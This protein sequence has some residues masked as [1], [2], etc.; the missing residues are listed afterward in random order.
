MNLVIAPLE[1]IA[2]EGL[3]GLLISAGAKGVPAAIVKRA[4]AIL[5]V[6]TSVTAI[7]SGNTVAGLSQLSTA[8]ATSD[9]DPGEALA[10]QGVV[11]QIATQASLLNN[12]LGST[13]LGTAGTAIYAN[14]ATG[15]TNACNAEIKKYGSPAAA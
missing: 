13:I 4:N 15:V 5:A 12:V 1:T 7:N 2:A 8:L 11:T 14:I 3:T 6:V 9:L 10:L